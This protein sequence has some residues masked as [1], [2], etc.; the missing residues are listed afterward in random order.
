MVTERQDEASFASKKEEKELIQIERCLK[1]W[2]HMQ[3]VAR[4]ARQSKIGDGKRD[5]QE[6]KGIVTSKKRATA[7]KVTGSLWVLQ[8]Q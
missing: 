2:Q 7:E 8:C 1:S 6:L 3:C 5:R 4:Q